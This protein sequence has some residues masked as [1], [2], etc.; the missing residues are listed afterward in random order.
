MIKFAENSK[1]IIL[2]ASELHIGQN[3]RITRLNDSAITHK[4]F[5]MGCVPGTKISL[6]FKSP[7]GDPIALDID[8]Y[9]LGL[10]LSEAEIIQ[11]EPEIG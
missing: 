1:S 5:E 2:N 4:L 11:V 7:A 9:I 6:E 8:G 10:R 3:A